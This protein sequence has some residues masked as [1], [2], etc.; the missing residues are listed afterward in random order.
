MGRLRSF[1]EL[2]NPER[3]SAAQAAS[4]RR[5]A[6][7]YI[8]TVPT[9]GYRF[10]VDVSVKPEDF[11]GSGIQEEQAASTR[12]TASNQTPRNGWTRYAWG[13]GIGAAVL[14][15]LCIGGFVYLRPSSPSPLFCTSVPLTNYVGSQICPYFAPDG[16]RVA[17]SW[18]GERQDNFDIYVKQVGEGTL[19][20]LTSD[21]RP[22]LSPA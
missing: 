10:L 7:G 20:R 4:R 6:T 15:L 17:F 1:R 2:T 16:E 3:G 11:V 18:D 19:L 21:P 22:D 12:H 13:I 8:G 5:E 14:G 9:V